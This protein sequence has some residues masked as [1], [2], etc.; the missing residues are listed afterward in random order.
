MAEPVAIIGGS[1]ALGL[2]L[3]RRLVA[4][5][6]DVTIGSRDASRAAE[7]AATIVGQGKATG[8]ANPDAAAAAGIVILSVPFSS[9]A[10]TIKEI[11]GS[12]AEGAVIVDATVPLATNVGGRPTQTLGVWAGSAAQQAASLIPD[13]VGIVAG[14]HTV[15]ADLLGDL[16]HDLDED[17]LLCGDDR[18][19]TARVAAV[20]DLIPG[21][22]C[23]DCGKL[24]MAR[25]TEQM[26]ALMI[27]MNIRH[28]ARTGVTI[29]GLPGAG[30]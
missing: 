9:Q 6:V 19:A 28:K 8:L 22:R 21:L 17:A 25:V 24:E 29:T 11:K 14:L 27:S 23:V 18:S 10:A 26:T 20:I 4:V 13:G 5:G 3:A 30:S 12:L 2:G 16:D 1:G 15:S 7:T